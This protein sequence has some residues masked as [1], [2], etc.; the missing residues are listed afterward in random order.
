MDMVPF[1]DCVASF[2]QSQQ[3]EGGSSLVQEILHKLNDRISDR[4]K[5]KCSGF[6]LYVFLL[7]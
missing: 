5:N 6:I 3:A 7:D 2:R 1:P 4:S